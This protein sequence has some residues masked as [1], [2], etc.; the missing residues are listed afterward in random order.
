MLSQTIKKLFYSKNLMLTIALS[1]YTIIVYMG[2]FV[3][4]L[5]KVD[6]ENLS[7]KEYNDYL[8][9]RTLGLQMVTSKEIEALVLGTF[10]SLSKSGNAKALNEY[11]D[12]FRGAFDIFGVYEKEINNNLSKDKIND[13]VGFCGFLVKAKDEQKFKNIVDL[14]DSYNKKESENCELQM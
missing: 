2:T 3:M 14:C 10:V 6:N 9:A 11:L 12:L 4:Y 13:G 1:Y 7:N 8:M 5:K